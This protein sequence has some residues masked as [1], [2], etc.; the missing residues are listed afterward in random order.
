[1]GK[2]IVE[3]ALLTDIPAGSIVY[4]YGLGNFSIAKK[5]YASFIQDKLLEIKD[6]QKRLKGEPTTLEICRQAHQDYLHN[7]SRSNQEKLRI[8]YENVPNHQKIYI[9]DMDTKDIEVRMIIYGEQEIE[10]WS[11]YVLAKKKGE[12][13]PTIKFPKPNDS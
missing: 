2:Y 1:M 9:G 11:H 8:A 10:N 4:I 6:I 3:G 13:L 12:T 7:P 5:L